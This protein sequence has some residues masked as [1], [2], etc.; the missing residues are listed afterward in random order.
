VEAEFSARLRERLETSASIALQR[1][2]EANGQ[3]LV[4][5]P[6]WVGKLR[7]SAPL[8]RNKLRAAMALQYL[9]T[10]RSMTPATVP[11][12]WLTDLSLTTNR[13]HPDFD[14]QFGVRNLLSQTY[15]DPVSFGLYQGQILQD[16]RS[17]FLRLIWRTKE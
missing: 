6:E 10:R 11:S 16:G 4:N 13:L 3:T 12:Y 15:Y 17:V 8:V 1:T 9:S 5:S 2:T 7:A 14:V